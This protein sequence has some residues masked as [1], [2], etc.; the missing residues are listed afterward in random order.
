MRRLVVL[1]NDLLS[2]LVVFL[3]LNLLAIALHYLVEQPLNNFLRQRP[4]FTP[5]S[6]HSAQPV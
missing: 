2:F 3:L 1:D 5:A 4:A 6:L